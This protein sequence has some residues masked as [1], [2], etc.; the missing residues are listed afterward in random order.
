MKRLFLVAL[1][2][3]FLGVGTMSLL[4]QGEPNPPRSDVKSG[5]QKPKDTPPKENPSAKK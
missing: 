4:A 3:T 1:A 2:A 5:K